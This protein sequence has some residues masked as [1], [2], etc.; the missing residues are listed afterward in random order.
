LRLVA[1]QFWQF[2][3]HGSEEELPFASPLRPGDCGVDQ[4]KMQA[5]GFLLSRFL[6]TAEGFPLPRP[7]KD[8]WGK[9]H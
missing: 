2:R 7:S 1:G 5:Y 9:V 6:V 8:L 3:I 4:F